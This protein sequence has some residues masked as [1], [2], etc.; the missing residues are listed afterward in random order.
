MLNLRKFI[1]F[2]SIFLISSAIT[3]AQ[4]EKRKK[5]DVYVTGGL[6]II[7]SGN[8]GLKIDGQELNSG[9]VRFAPVFNW[10][11][12]VNID[13]SPHF[14]LF[15]GLGIR[16]VG[17]IFD[18]PDAYIDKT[19]VDG[20]VRKK[21]RTYNLGIP[22]GIKFGNLH[23]MFFYAGYEFEAPFQY[24]EKTFV[25]ERKQD[26]FSVWFTDR[27]NLQHSLMFGIQFPYGTNLKMKY[28]LNNYFNSSWGEG[29]SKMVGTTMNYNQLSGNVFYV[30]LNFSI[31]RNTKFYY[32]EYEK[33]HTF[34]ES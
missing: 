24:K 34:P 1:F 19:K 31:F 25:S 11:S 16:N 10:Q 12:L 29:Q 26:K 22:V 28:Y 30:S 4:S 27:V 32:S 21:V 14:G 3:F 8:T 20:P 5:A 2:T 6:E 18:V 7:L 9:V 15:T 33:K 23:G 17:M 13:F